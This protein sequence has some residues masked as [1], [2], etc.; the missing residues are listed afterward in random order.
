LKGEKANPSNESVAEVWG[1][2]YLDGGVIVRFPHDEIGR[3]AQDLKVRS[4][5][6]MTG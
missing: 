5:G 4:M 6:G 2:V 3:R 1:K